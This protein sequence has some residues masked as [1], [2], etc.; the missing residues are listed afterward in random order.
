MM[1]KSAGSTKVKHLKSQG[2]PVHGHITQMATVISINNF[3]SEPS[4]FKTSKYRGADKSL[5]WTGFKSTR[6]GFS[7]DFHKHWY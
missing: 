4:S 1:Y 7:V 6:V 2:P 5:A 3:L